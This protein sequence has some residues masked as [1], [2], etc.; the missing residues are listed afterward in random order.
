MKKQILTMIMLGGLLISTTT[1]IFA[2]SVAGP[3]KH[4][5][6]V[7]AVNTKDGTFTIMDAEIRKPITFSASTKILKN[8]A[9]STGSVMVS[10]EKTDSKMV[11]KDIHF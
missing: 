10:Y 7:T 8:A 6:Q 3:N 5:G 9:K 11:A 2:C 1:P 4:V